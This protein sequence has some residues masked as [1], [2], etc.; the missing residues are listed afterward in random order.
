MQVEFP[1]WIRELLSL[2][3]K[4]E[5]N[6]T[7][8]WGTDTMATNQDNGTVKMSSSLTT[9]MLKGIYNKCNNFLTKWE[10][11]SWQ[12]ICNSLWTLHNASLWFLSK[13]P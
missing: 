5:H 6:S 8:C 13:T 4:C 2:N 12:D 7:P 9:M 1:G 11:N 10:K 3:V